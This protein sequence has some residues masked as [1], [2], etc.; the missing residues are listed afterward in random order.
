MKQ[1]KYFTENPAAV[2]HATD[3]LARQG[4]D[5]R[6]LKIFSRD[7]SNHQYDGLLVQTENNS[8]SH[9]LATGILFYACFFIMGSVAIS[10]SLI[11]FT[12]LACLVFGIVIFTKAVSF[13]RLVFL[14]APRPSKEV[15]FLVVDVDSHSEK[16]VSKVASAE[17]MLLA[18]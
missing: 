9:D 7:N 16:I 12:M 2:K 3:A 4:F 17:P 14:S 8:Q 15:Y 10:S 5:T 6:R 18:Q 1:L 13:T 11:S